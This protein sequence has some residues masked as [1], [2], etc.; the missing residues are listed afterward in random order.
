MHADHVGDVSRIAD[1]GALRSRRRHSRR[2]LSDLDLPEPFELT[3]FVERVARSRSRPIHLVPVRGAMAG[4][5]PCGWWCPA[6]DF[7]AIFLDDA[8]TALH[9]QHIVLHE[10]GHMLWG[11][12]PDIAAAPLLERAT[13]HLRW[14]SASM[15]AMLGRSDYDS[16]REQEAEVFATQAGIKISSMRGGRRDLPTE[17]VQRLTEALYLGGELT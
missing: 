14:D 17:D 12:T 13:S 6:R 3:V 5:S 9:R 2:L 15:R 10:V 1:I 16:A 4:G 11:H 8:A 7:D